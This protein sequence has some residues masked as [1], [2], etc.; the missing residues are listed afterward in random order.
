MDWARSDAL[1][2]VASGRGRDVLIALHLLLSLACLF[3]G[4]CLLAILDQLLRGKTDD[5]NLHVGTAIAVSG[6]GG[7]LFPFWGWASTVG[8]LAVLS[9]WTL[10]GGLIER[11][12]RS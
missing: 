3:V 11:L 4:T 12:S 6:V 7:L 1:P 2:R 8:L 10:V 5:L 9:I